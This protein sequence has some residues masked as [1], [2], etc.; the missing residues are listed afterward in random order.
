MEFEQLKKDYKELET[1]GKAHDEELTRLLSPVAQ[2][3]SGNDP[4]ILVLVFNFSLMFTERLVYLSRAEALGIP[5]ILPN[6]LRVDALLDAAARVHSHGAKAKDV[7]GG[8]ASILSEVFEQLS[9]G[10][11]IP[12]SL[13]ELVQS[14]LAK[15]DLFGEY[16]K[17][18]TKAGAKAA[19]TFAL[20]SGIEGDYEKAY[21][22]HPRPPDG[23]KVQLKPFADRAGKLSELLANLLIKLHAS[24]AS[25]STSASVV[26]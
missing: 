14:L 3:L 11:P 15:E 18:K 17:E 23:K 1:S 19:I 16:Y 2:G 9:P 25:T 8:V 5:E 12:S 20:A 22:D 10:Q 13:P 7:L 26:P 4:L 6:Q 24:K 21:E